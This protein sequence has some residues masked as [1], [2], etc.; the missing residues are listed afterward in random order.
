MRPA[1][2]SQIGTDAVCAGCGVLFVRRKFLQQYHDNRCKTSRGPYG[3]VTQRG[4]RGH[5]I[6]RDDRKLIVGY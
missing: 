1:S 2:G 6:G 3:F 5:E 4:L